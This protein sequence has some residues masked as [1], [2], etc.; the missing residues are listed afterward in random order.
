MDIRFP[1]SHDDGPLAYG[2]EADGNEC[3][4]NYFSEKLAS[5]FGI[6]KPGTIAFW[7]EQAWDKTQIFDDEIS[8]MVDVSDDEMVYLVFRGLCMGWGWSL[9]NESINQIVSGFIE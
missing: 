2:I 3:F 7:R 8:S 5:W 1:P 9:A 6:D 4:Y